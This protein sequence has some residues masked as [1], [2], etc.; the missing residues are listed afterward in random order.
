MGDAASRHGTLAKT[1]PPARAVNR[2]A[3]LVEARRIGEAGPV[4]TETAA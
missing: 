1:L 2:L 4:A 3:P